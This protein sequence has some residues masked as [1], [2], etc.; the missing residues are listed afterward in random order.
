[1]G[2]SGGKTEESEKLVLK[3][4]LRVVGGGGE[5]ENEFAKIKK[6]EKEKCV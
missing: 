5:E 2:Y 4:R 6:K 3:E 1:M